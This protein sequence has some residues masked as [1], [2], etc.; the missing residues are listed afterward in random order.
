MV[1][2]YV[3][4]DTEYESGFTA[5]HGADTR[6]ANF[7]RAIRGATSDGDVG[8]FHQMD[9]FDRHGLKAVFFVD[10]MPALIWGTGAVADV[11]EPIV[12]R[13]HDVQLHLHTEWLAIAGNANPVGP[14]RGPNL[15]D[16]S[17]EE[18]CRLLDY[19]AQVLM[20]AGAPRPV[21]F[22]AGNYGANDDT[23]RAL[24][25]LG[26]THDTSHPPG[27]MD[28]SCAIAL[29]ENDR[30]PLEMHGV[31]EVP[32]GCI[33]D[34]FGGLRHA[35]LTALSYREIVAA[36]RHARGSGNQQ[37]TLVSHSFELLCR[38]RTRIN[39]IV[40]RRFEKVCAMVAKMKGVT[41]ATYAQQAPRPARE[42]A[43][44]MPAAPLLNGSRLMEQAIANA[45]YG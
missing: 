32:I 21:A 12:R 35:Q 26:L 31:V 45:L 38:K 7:D 33:E 28:G 42:T 20:D 44:V 4:I 39:R 24:A 41:T 36:L 19:A 10:P 5:R 40:T 13:G 27:L 29:T 1:S 9:V 23:L 37:F 11:V 14:G 25:T 15:K 6:A 17:F 30:A 18:Q 2:L 8:I 3:T 43:P 34:A 22:R 16:Y